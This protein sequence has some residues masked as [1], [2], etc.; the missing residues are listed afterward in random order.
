MLVFRSITPILVKVIKET[1]V[2]HSVM[3]Q[4]LKMM[5]EIEPL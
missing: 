5:S 3:T 2:S 4:T 1:S